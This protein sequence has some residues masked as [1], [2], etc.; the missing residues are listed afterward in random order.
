VEVFPLSSEFL[1]IFI[2]FVNYFSRK[3]IP[4]YFWCPWQAV[5]GVLDKGGLQAS[6]DCQCPWC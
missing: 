1:V 3:E 5:T 4:F 6:S 2:C